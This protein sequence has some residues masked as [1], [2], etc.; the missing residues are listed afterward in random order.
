MSIEILEFNPLHPVWDHGFGPQ[1]ASDMS[2]RQAMCTTWQS[3]G[4]LM[5]CFIGSNGS[6]ILTLMLANCWQ[7]AHALGLHFGN[8]NYT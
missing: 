5:T 2:T 6:E 7:L 8:H 3:C 4:P 1:H